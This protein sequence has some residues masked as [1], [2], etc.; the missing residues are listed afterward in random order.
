MHSFE[1]LS[2]LEKEH[3][4][5]AI[6]GILRKRVLDYSKNFKTSWVNLGQALYSVWQDKLYSAWGYDKFEY[7][8]E[9]E[10]GLPKQISLRLLKTYAFLE[11]EEPAYLKKEFRETREA[12]KVPGYEAVNVLRLARQK[13]ELLKDDYMKLRKDVFD[14]GKEASAVRK[15]LLALMKERKPVD[16]EKER[17]KRSEMTIRRLYHA[18]DSF[19]K[20]M[21]VLKIIP[22]HIIHDAKDLMDKLKDLI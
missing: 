7:Y 4:A 8:T 18:L 20:D 11:S 15:D 12:A 5:D 2:G 16:P 1:K 13:R 9:Q 6:G 3:A 19:K 21:E 14:K 22:D 17:H 10:V